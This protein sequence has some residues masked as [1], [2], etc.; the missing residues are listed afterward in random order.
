MVGRY[1]AFVMLIINI[2][3]GV[4]DGALPVRI[5]FSVVLAG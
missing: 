5:A 3:L 4:E 2:N 1:Y